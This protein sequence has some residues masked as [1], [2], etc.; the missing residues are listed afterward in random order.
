MYD[1]VARCVGPSDAFSEEVLAGLS[2]PQKTISSRWLYDDLGSALFEEITQ[3][4]EYYP[5]RT[6]LS[7]LSEH[8]EQIAAFCGEQAVLIEYG[9]GAAIKTE[10]LLDAL[11]APRLYVPVDI[12][13]E[14][15]DSTVSRL[16]KRFAQLRTRPIIADFTAPIHLPPWVPVERRLGFFPGST[17]GNLNVAEARLFLQRVRHHVGRNG[18]AL[19]GVDMKKALSILIPAYDD[20]RGVTAQFNLNLLRRMNRELDANFILEAFMHHVRWNTHES[21]IE[22]HLV[23]RCRQTVRAAQR[24]F[25]FEAGETIHTESSRKYDRA[26][27]ERLAQEAGWKLSRHWTDRGGLFSLF[28]LEAV[29]S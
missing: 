19:I 5:S 22:M 20:R 28:G 1:A 7:I 29:S 23:S 17:L 18:C 8:A 10:I 11:R 21:A 16:R 2:Q 6:E 3:L 15:L 9:A 27:F 24:H 12:A 25:S 13:G 4:D 14:F 26:A